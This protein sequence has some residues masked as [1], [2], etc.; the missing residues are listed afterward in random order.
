VTKRRVGRTQYLQKQVA[1]PRIES[2]GGKTIWGA[3]IKP[4]NSRAG[5][6]KVEGAN[7]EAIY[8]E[9]GGFNE[10]ND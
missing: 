6:D 1:R 5:W 10:P 9:R 3:L 4:L 8:G 2:A 7:L